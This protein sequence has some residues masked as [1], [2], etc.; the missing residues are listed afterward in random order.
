MVLSQMY[1][2]EIIVISIE[3]DHP[4]YFGNG[5]GYNKRMYLLF[6]GIH[7]DVIVRSFAEG[8]EEGYDTLT[9]EPGD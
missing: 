5:K 6:D 8:L 9:F 4:Y 3:Y 2:C 7:Y 1:K